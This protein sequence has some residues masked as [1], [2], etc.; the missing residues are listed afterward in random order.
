MFVHQ[1]KIVEGNEDYETDFGRSS[2]TL[3]EMGDSFD[4]VAKKWS[5]NFFDTLPE[6]KYS[7]IWSR[8]GNNG[9]VRIGAE[10]Q[11]NALCCFAM[12]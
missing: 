6:S 12:K 7:D 3:I 10:I 9:T 4:E 8:K 2:T 11:K 1:A 5:F